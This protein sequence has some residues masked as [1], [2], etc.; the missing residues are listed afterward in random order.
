M[1][2]FY[3]NAD[4][5]GFLSFDLFDVIQGSDQGRLPLQCLGIILVVNHVALG[6]KPPT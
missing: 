5:L 3:F 6:I 2:L 4:I 1:F